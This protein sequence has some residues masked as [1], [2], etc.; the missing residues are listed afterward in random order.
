MATKFLLFVETDWDFSL[1]F[2]GELFCNYEITLQLES[3]QQL[4]D[5]K[6]LGPF[7]TLAGGKTWEW[8]H[9]VK[10]IRANPSESF[11]ELGGNR[12]VQ[13]IVL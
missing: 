4:D 6:V 2:H 9:A 11:S 3:V 10:R 1:E 7:G 12:G 13:W 8:E 5:I